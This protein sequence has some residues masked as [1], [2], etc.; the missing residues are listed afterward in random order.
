MN[1][2]LILVIK[3]GEI[4]ERGNHNFLVELGGLY[5]E[6]WK[7]QDDSFQNELKEDI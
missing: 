7:N 3:D 2:D 4:L 5:S 6:M 1:A